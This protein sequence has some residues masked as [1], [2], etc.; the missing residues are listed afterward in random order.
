MK[1]ESILIIGGSI[2]GL[3]CALALKGKG[4]DVTILERD[5]APS[6]DITPATSHRWKRNGTPHAVQ[7]HTL[8]ASIRNL[9]RD[10]YPDLLQELIDAG[11]GEHHFE[12][13]FHKE[14]AGKYRPV[15]E[16]AEITTLMSRRT[17][18]ELVLRR[19]VERQAIAQL[20]VGAKVRSLLTEKQDDGTIVVRGVSI[21]D[22]EGCREIRS[23]VVIDASG[24]GSGFFQSLV[25]AGADIREEYYAS[26][27]AYF[28]RSYKLADGTTLPKALI[29]V[30]QTP[31]MTMSLMSGDNGTAT[32]TLAAFKD[33]PLLYGHLGDTEVFDAV[34][35][36]VPNIAEWINPT[37]FLPTTGVNR[38]ANMDATWRHSVSDG[39]PRLLGFFFAG[40]TALRSNPKFGRGCACA[41]IGSHILADILVEQDSPRERAIRYEAG[42]KQ[43][44]RAEWE[45]LLTTDRND[46][47]AFRASVGLKPKSW[48]DRLRYIIGRQVNRAMQIDPEVRRAIVYAGNGITDLT[49]WLKGPRIWLRILRSA[50]AGPIER[51]VI[52]RH[53]TCVDRRAIAQM[54]QT[55]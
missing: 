37:H 19:Y 6:P 49:A 52:A 39:S 8:I 15:S 51:R 40:D 26:N 43:A 17:T 3:A 36:S 47:E 38:W 28:T 27:V 23:D 50:F 18:L 30:S 33:D 55:V 16:D 7:P 24:R 4:F 41:L 54:I 31:H 53:E 32:V 35:A 44:F 29:R 14:I 21:K 42:L 45:F 1:A 22:G 48:R 10:R 2:A 11:V 34:I 13:G 9:L 12:D 20:I 46:Y 5:P 25:Q